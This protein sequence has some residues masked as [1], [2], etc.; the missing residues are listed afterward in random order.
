MELDLQ[1]RWNDC[2]SLAGGVVDPIHGLDYRAATENAIEYISKLGVNVTGN[3]S[4]WSAV[5]E[6]VKAPV[7][8]GRRGNMT[9]WDLLQSY[10]SGDVRSGELWIEAMRNL[11]GRRHLVPSKGLYETLQAHVMEMADSE[12]AED[13]HTETDVLLASLTLAEWKKIAV[14]G[15]RGQVVTVA[16]TGDR[17]LLLDYLESIL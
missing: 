4:R 10:A 8:R 17:A 15:L 11:K 5:S 6:L 3:A 1:F 9:T 14:A 16:S 2:V 7:K 12:L 13:T